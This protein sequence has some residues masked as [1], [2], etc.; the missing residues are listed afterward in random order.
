MGTKNG[1]RRNGKERKK[2]RKKKEKRKKEKKRR[3][4]KEEDE[5]ERENEKRE[6][7]SHM[8][9]LAWMEKTGD[10]QIRYFM[11]KLLDIEKEMSS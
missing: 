6:R 8:C 3:E 2:K 11:Q 10:K 1:K 7:M 4:W 5:K 9:L